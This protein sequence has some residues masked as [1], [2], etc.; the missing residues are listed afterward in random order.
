M[1]FEITPVAG[2]VQELDVDLSKPSQHEREEFVIE[3][4]KKAIDHIVTALGGYLSVSCNGNINP[5][6]G[7]SG[8]L[9]NIYI[10]SLPVPASAAPETV[11][12][13]QEGLGIPEEISPEKELTQ[14]QKEESVALNPIEPPQP[15][16]APVEW[17]NHPTQEITQPPVIEQTP[18]LVNPT[19]TPSQPVENPPVVPEQPES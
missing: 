6:S 10:T 2:T 14:G 4:V 5:I 3:E 7:E 1:T 12:P 16:T 19:P 17:T 13:T 15:E 8:D 11:V 18:S 9:V